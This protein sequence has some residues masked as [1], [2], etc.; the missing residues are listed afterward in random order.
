M[1][2]DI[3]DKL[4]FLRDLTPAQRSVLRPIFVPC[5]C[6]TDDLLFAQGDPADY[7]YLVVSGEVIIN[8]QPEDGTEILVTHVREGGIV[9]WSA[10]LGN[11]CY[12]SSASCTCYTQML[13]VRGSDLRNLCQ[14]YP[15]TGILILDRLATVIAERL[16]NTHDQVISL[17]KQGLLNEI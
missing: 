14:D 8:Y 6:Y 5:D 4:P 7:L 9:G 1:P 17:L 15:D 13:R 2:V 11:R 10:A 12:T 3:F 16:R